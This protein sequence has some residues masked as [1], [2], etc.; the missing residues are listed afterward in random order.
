MEVRW[1]WDLGVR[2]RWMLYCRQYSLAEFLVG[3][4]IMV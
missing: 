3:A 1:E 2:M 4:L